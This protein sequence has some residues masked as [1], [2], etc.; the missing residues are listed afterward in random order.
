[1]STYNVLV[2]HHVNCPQHDEPIVEYDI[3]SI[4]GFRDLI[5][6]IS[7]GFGEYKILQ[8]VESSNS[9]HARYPIVTVR[10][11]YENHAVSK[12]EIAFDQD[13]AASG[14][15]L[16][17]WT[18]Y[19]RDDGFFDSEGNSIEE[20]IEKHLA[21]WFDHLRN[22]DNEMFKRI[23]EMVK[24]SQESKHALELKAGRLFV[25]RGDVTSTGITF[26]AFDVHCI[27]CAAVGKFGV[28]WHENS[29]PG[30]S[31]ICEI[32]TLV[33]DAFPELTEHEVSMLSVHDFSMFNTKE[34][35][36]KFFKVLDTHLGKRHAFALLIDDQ[37]LPI[38][39]IS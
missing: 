1:M 6:F 23:A 28:Y 16:G 11:Y 27:A 18:C 30:S 8:V 31:L 7:R 3:K 13:Q 26:G 4:A 29:E 10:E 39:E 14:F 9:K 2:A 25:S 20:V 38:T 19:D 36:W 21:S 12:I 34:D 32:H 35:A 17:P 33:K 24:K 5:D 15:M 22:S 37:G